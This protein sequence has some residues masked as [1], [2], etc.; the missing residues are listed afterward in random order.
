MNSDARPPRPP[1][2]RSGLLGDFTIT[3]DG[4]RERVHVDAHVTSSASLALTLDHEMAH[5][6]TVLGTGY[7]L[8]Q[9]Y[10]AIAADAPDRGEALGFSDAPA[11]AR[12]L[13]EQSWMTHEGYAVAIERI[14]ATTHG[15]VPPPLPHRYKEAWS[16][17]DHILSSLPNDR[18]Y[19]APFFLRALVEH[20]LGAQPVPGWDPRRGMD[21]AL[22]RELVRDERHHPDVRLIE[23]T[24]TWDD[25]SPSDAIPKATAALV[26][27]IVAH[28]KCHAHQVP[29]LMRAIS[30]PAPNAESA[31][32]LYQLG[33]QVTDYFVEL[34]GL[35]T[36]TPGGDVAPESRNRF[37]RSTAD[38]FRS[39]GV[40]CMA[41]ESR[42]PGAELTTAMALAE[43]EVRYERDRHFKDVPF[44][45][46]SA[47]SWRDLV[48]SKLSP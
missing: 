3:A 19:L 45:Y 2:L 40:P 11:D 23:M 10:L 15:V 24:M 34:V 31:T 41:I 32:V 27:S 35:L 36:P 8:A 42:P 16:Y 12:R 48:K 1:V 4:P 9:T 38:R 21:E 22:A 46:T 29:G 18:L 39:K 28:F 20:C 7:G 30:G 44:E 37:A 43:F 26:E 13:A 14:H 5:R 6:R 17:Y 33:Y 25:R 47:E